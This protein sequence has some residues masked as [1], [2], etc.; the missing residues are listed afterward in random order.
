M[1]R[2]EGYN[3]KPIEEI[4]LVLIFSVGIAK[5]LPLITIVKKKSKRV[6]CFLG[7]RFFQGKNTTWF[8]T[9]VKCNGNQGTDL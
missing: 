4:N 7:W 1:E 5:N 6:S 2:S 9:I 3:E 8:L